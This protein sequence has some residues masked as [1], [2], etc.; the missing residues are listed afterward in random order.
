MCVATGE[1]RVRRRSFCGMLTR[2]A[3][4]CSMIVINACGVREVSPEY[5]QFP[6]KVHDLDVRVFHF[7]DFR[8][9][10]QNKPE[11]CWAAAL[12]QALALQGV[13][14]SQEQL[15]WK[16]LGT[17]RA[18]TIGIASWLRDVDGTAVRAADGS[19][20][21]IKAEAY[22][23]L[24]RTR[25]NEVADLFLGSVTPV[26]GPKPATGVLSQQDFFDELAQ[27]VS[28]KRIPL[29]GIETRAGARHMVTV[30]GIA[31]PLMDPRY[32]P[33]EVV[34]FLIYDPWTA[35]LQLA[36]IHDL[37]KVSVAMFPVAIADSNM[38]LPLVPATYKRSF[39]FSK[40]LLSAG[41]GVNPLPSTASLNVW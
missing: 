8:R 3:L 16:V 30:V 27:E 1:D 22:T 12:E 20:V 19:K 21:W 28:H 36:T 14:M 11:L 39:A 29:L 35:S 32:T 34:A 4:L 5:A 7:A 31:F 9:V 23:P 18:R 10:H 33:E 2:V 26:V 15:L 24:K 40:S 25:L 6:A 13:E 41:I 38:T 17:D 37:A